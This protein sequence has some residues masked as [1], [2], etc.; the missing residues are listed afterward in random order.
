MSRER[1]IDRACAIEA[2]I[3]ASDRPVEAERLAAIVAEVD[4]VDTPSLEKIDELIDHLNCCYA[5]QGRPFR[6]QNWAGGY[7]MTTTED[8]A[9][10]LKAFLRRTRR[11]R[12]TRALMETLAIICYKQ[13]VTKQAVEDIRGVASDYTVRRLMEV[14]LVGII[15]R[16]ELVGRPI[17][18]GTT[19]RFLEEFG[20]R[21]LEALPNLKEIEELLQDPEFDQ[22]KARLLGL[23]GGQ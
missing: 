17:L 16:A 9:P 20:L 4:E 7:R 14:G 22:E 18:Y 19:D 5:E 12:L 6:I 15:G 11:V 10:Y 21:D 13:P 2:M 8:V 23:D 1:R 3:F